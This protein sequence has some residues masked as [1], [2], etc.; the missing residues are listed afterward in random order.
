MA[1]K[2]RKTPTCAEREHLRRENERRAKRMKVKK[3]GEGGEVKQDEERG[4]KI[5][6]TKQ[7][8]KALKEIKKY[9]NGTEMLIR[10]LPFQ[11]VVKEIIQ[12]IQGDLRLQSTAIMVLQEVGETFLVGLLEQSN[13]FVLHAKRV[14]IMPKGVQLARCIRGM[15]NKG[16]KKEKTKEHMNVMGKKHNRS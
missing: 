4:K 1:C 12:K 9:Q 7:G 14:T 2:V 3:K 11:R 15:F 10:R 5:K 6:K 16:I 13:L 8:L